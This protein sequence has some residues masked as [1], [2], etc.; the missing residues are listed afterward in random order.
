MSHADLSSLDFGGSR[1]RSYLVGED[2]EQDE[3]KGFRIGGR[4][5][6][7]AHKGQGGIV[8]KM[9][10]MH[11]STEE[12]EEDRRKG[13]LWKCAFLDRSA[14]PQISNRGR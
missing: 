5:R 8:Q 10:P 11:F 7:A 1:H 12:Q 14:N 13:E 3:E 9:L 4:V 2:K 6:S